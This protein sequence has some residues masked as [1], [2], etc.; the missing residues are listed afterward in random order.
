MSVG[1]GIFYGLVFLGLIYLYIQTRDRWNWKRIVLWTIGCFVAL[2]VI[3]VIYIS[4]IDYF[5][6]TTFIPV[7]PSVVNTL[8]DVSI[9]EK[10]LDVQFR[11][12]AKL[13]KKDGE[14]TYEFPNQTNVF[15]QADNNG[16]VDRVGNWCSSDAFTYPY[17]NSPVANDIRC[18]D[19]SERILEKFGGK[20]NVRILCLKKRINNIDPESARSYD[21]VEYGVRFVLITNKVSGIYIY[22][23]E[24]LKKS[25]MSE[26][27]GECK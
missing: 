20:D 17:L 10:V 24:E 7:K 3:F 2:I 22:R 25:D 21:A 12:G 13:K 15:F 6:K 4:T 23:P 9:G 18:G 1:E 16:L 14:L 27:W 8:N 26:N 11:T 5:A 19:S